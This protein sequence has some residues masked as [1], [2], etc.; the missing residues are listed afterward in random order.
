MMPDATMDDAE[1]EDDSVDDV[2]MLRAVAAAPLIGFGPERLPARTIVAQSYELSRV[3]GAGAMGVVYEATDLV[4]LRKVAVKLHEIG[5]SDRAARMWREARAM[6]RLSDPHVVAVHEVG[7]DDARGYI[8]MELVDG[9]N[10][11]EWVAAK[12]PTWREIV[13]V[14]RQAGRGL[15]AAHAVGITHRDFKPDNVLVSVDGRVKVADFGLAMD[16]A[17]LDAGTTLELVPTM[18]PMDRRATR[19]GATLG[20]PAYMAPEQARGERADARSD[21]Y[22]FCVALHEALHGT[23]PDGSAP[24]R[25]PIIAAPDVPRWV[26]DVI[27]KGLASDPEARHR[28]MVRVV[29]AL[30]PAPRR[31]RK[32][33]LALGATTVVG[34]AALVW[35]GGVLAARERELPCV[36][37]D[38]AMDPTWSEGTKSELADAFAARSE[39]LAKAALGTIGPR[40]DAW[41]DGWRAAARESCEATHVLGQ[42]SAQRLDARNDCLER[43]RRRFAATIELLRAADVDAMAR[44]DEIVA[45]LPDVAMCGRADAGLAADVVA[46]ERRETYDA[47]LAAL[48]EAA[49]EA[50]AG[51]DAAA[52]AK[53]DALLVELEADGFAHLHNEALRK[54]GESQ[55]ALG[56]RTEAIEDLGTAVA[57]SHGA[58]DRDALALAMT[59]LARAL[60]RTSGGHDEALRVLAGARALADALEWSPARRVGLDLVAF[61]AAFYAERYDDADALADALLAEPALDPARRVRVRSLRATILERRTRFDDA[62][63][64]HDE[65]LAYVEGLWGPDHPAVAGVLGN[66]ANTLQAMRRNDEGRTSL[67]RAL[68]I[69]IAALGESAPAVGELH[70]QLGDQEMQDLRHDAAR[71]QY[72]KA[73]AIAR[74]A[75]DDTGLSLALANLTRVEEDLGDHS[76]S[77]LLMDEA[78]AAGERAFGPTSLQVARMLV[79]R[80][81]SRLAANEL[82]Q[83]AAEH[84]RALALFV[85]NLPATDPALA[86]A[87]LGLAGFYA[88]LGRHDEALALHQEGSRGLAAAYPDDKQRLVALENSTALM[89]DTIGRKDAA[90][91]QWRAMVELAERTLAPEDQLRHEMLLDYGMRLIEAGDLAGART[92]LRAAQELHTRH[93]TEA[94][95]GAKIAEGLARASRGR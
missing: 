8:A 36:A 15:A 72:E 46:P 13:E 86:V 79:N 30:D 65:T 54:R 83:G 26:D 21:Q 52:K 81:L 82:T 69:R 28:D 57:S 95:R 40:F 75:G 20:T 61:E 25:R 90:L 53:L 49:V 39:S 87:R 47:R 85:A 62:L 45:S 92:Q 50:A 68:A 76:K 11:R 73:I 66:R 59:S 17:A 51:R 70:R 67:E 34:G 33:A 37:A 77:A 10:A 31:R 12:R 63:A 22:S 16:P 88:R 94:S 55:L 80:G 29:A 3:I 93:G 60:G 42:Q 44:A 2:R 1:E 6:A 38:A 7:V 35:A 4:L 89:L 19:T 18:T 43:T 48:D 23:W 5:R 14:Y 71:A 32:L 24:S 78:I 91:V 27:A 84:E 64:A 74:A 58:G 56:R 41:A 9:T